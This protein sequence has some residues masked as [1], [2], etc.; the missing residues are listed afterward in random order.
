M[1]LPKEI[2]EIMKDKVLADSEAPVYSRVIM[3][4][5]AL[6]EG[7]FFNEYIKRGSRIL[8]LPGTEQ[9]F[10]CPTGNVLMLSEGKFGVDNVYCLREGMSSG[11][12][13]LVKT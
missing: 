6:L 5:K 10:D 7:E 1:I 4:L 3:P 8:S 12:G 2:Y 9:Q 13:N 11:Q